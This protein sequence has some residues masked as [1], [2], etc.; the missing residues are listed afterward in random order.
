MSNEPTTVVGARITKRDAALLDA[1]AKE[2]GCDRSEAIRI[3]LSLGLPLAS[4]DTKLNHRRNASL[5][6][7]TAAGIGIIIRQHHPDHE[8]DLKTM[9][10]ERVARYHA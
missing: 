6:E 8:D 7:F 10:Q 5:L 1:L 2:R 9:V 3:A 4:S